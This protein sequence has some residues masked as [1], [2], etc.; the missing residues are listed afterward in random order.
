MTFDTTTII[1]AA[2]YDTEI[3]KFGVY[4]LSFF[5]DTRMF[6]GGSPK[7]LYEH[8]NLVGGSGSLPRGYSIIAQSICVELG[9]EIGD[10][11]REI[12]EASELVLDIGGTPD[13]ERVKIA[14]AIRPRGAALSKPREIIELQTMA[15]RWDEIPVGL[16]GPFSMKV[17]LAGALTAPVASGRFVSLEDAK[18][19]LKEIYGRKEPTALAAAWIHLAC[20]EA[21]EAL[22]KGPLTRR[23]YES[24]R[25]RSLD[26]RGAPKGDKRRNTR[27]AWWCIRCHAKVRQSDQVAAVRVRS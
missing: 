13:A 5:S 3:V 25:I 20:V 8:T 14:D 17:M 19:R 18:K 26:L 23:A 12:T 21:N 11:D 24:H 15:I 4:R 6:S 16:K 22:V 2:I 7:R 27:R 1:D 9:D 10:G